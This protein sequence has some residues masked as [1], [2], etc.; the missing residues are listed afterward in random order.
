MPVWYKNRPLGKNK[1]E[2]MMREISKSAG[3][4]K[5]YMNHCVRDCSLFIGST[6][7]VFQGTGQGLFLMLLSTGH[8][9]FLC[10]YSTGHELFLEKISQIIFV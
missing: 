3:L 4:S 6:G 9:D 1:L 5:V 10:F 7:L 8:R 2:T